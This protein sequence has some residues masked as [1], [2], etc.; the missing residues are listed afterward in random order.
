MKKNFTP[1]PKVSSDNSKSTTKVSNNNQ[2]T[3]KATTS[4][5]PQRLSALKKNNPQVFQ[6]TA[7]ILKKKY[8]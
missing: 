3:N 2:S 1:K 6:T 5:F 7:Q 4:N 8:N